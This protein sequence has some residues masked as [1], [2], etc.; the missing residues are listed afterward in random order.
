MHAIRFFNGHFHQQWIDG[1]PISASRH[2]LPAETIGP[3]DALVSRA[4]PGNMP[5]S[6]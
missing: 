3:D 1:S 2:K 4:Q 6:S 5:L